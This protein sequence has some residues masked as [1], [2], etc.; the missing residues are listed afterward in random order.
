MPKS[1]NGDGEAIRSCRE[2]KKK[3]EPAQVNTPSLRIKTPLQGSGCEPGLRD[4]TGTRERHT[5][6]FRSKGLGGRNSPRT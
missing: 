3:G 5:L 1:G 2:G 6:W 4:V